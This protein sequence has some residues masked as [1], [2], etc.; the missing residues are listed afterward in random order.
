MLSDDVI[1]ARLTTV[2]R[3]IFDNDDIEVTG[4][5]TA[6]DI[7]GWDSLAHIK[8]VLAVEREFNMKFKTA[9]IGDLAFASDMIDIIRR[10][11]PG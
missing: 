4:D 6:M 8:L 11:A 3:D 5:M 9:E 2:F 1:L 10:T 7:E